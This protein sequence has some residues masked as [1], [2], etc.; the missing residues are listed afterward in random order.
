VS[1]LCETNYTLKGILETLDKIQYSNHSFQ[2][3]KIK[4]LPT[5]LLTHQNEILSKLNIKLPAY[6]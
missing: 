4:L 1:E 5:K 2:K 6:L 3:I